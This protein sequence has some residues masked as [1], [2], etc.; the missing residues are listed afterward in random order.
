MSD[1]GAQ[2]IIAAMILS[3]SMVGGAYLVSESIDRVTEQIPKFETAMKSLQTAVAA[4]AG[5]A[6]AAPAAPARRRGP[7]PAKV[8]KL[9]SIGAPT[10]GPDSATV[11]VVEFS[12]FQ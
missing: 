5:T 8:Y 9:A 7:D 11:K 1:K 6:A 2:V 4:G 3:L 10:K 12:D